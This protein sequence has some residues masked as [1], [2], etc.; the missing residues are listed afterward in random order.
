MRMLK[1][2]GMVLLGLVAWFG[3]VQVFM[4]AIFAEPD[5]KAASLVEQ[6]HKRNRD[7][8]P[9]GCAMNPAVKAAL[10]VEAPTLPKEEKVRTPL[11][12]ALQALTV[13][14]VNPEARTVLIGARRIKVGEH[15]VFVHEDTNLRLA[16]TAVAL[17]EITITDLDTGENACREISIAPKF[18]SMT[19]A[20]LQPQ[21]QPLHGPLTVR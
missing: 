4:G 12:T 8:D 9:F 18:Q 10:V 19:G 1:H 2:R 7:I 17:T 3:G 20:P 21:L 15:F 6:L 14:G 5:P 11:Q 16:L 13:N